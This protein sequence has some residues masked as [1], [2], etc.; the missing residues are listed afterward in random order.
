MDEFTIKVNRAR[1]LKEQAKSLEEEAQEILESLGDLPYGTYGTTNGY[2]LQITPT[3]R[4]DAA[5]AHRNLEP[6]EFQ[7]ILKAKPDAALAKALLGEDRYKATQKLHG[8]TRKII[9]V[10][11]E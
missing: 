2:A 1:L 11:V 6:E 9:K 7:S 10:E 5:E 3:L 8:V 4:F